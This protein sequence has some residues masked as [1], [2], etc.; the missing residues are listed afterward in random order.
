MPF[1]RLMVDHFECPDILYRQSEISL[2]SAEIIQRW[3][4]LVNG[5]RAY[6]H[7]LAHFFYAR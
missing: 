2:Q 1:C 4:A 7:D 5:V 3:W 6:V